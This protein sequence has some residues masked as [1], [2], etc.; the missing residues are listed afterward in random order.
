MKSSC[1]YLTIWYSLLI[2]FFLVVA[3]CTHRSTGVFPVDEG[4]ILT[5]ELALNFS[6]KALVECGK[7]S[8]MMKPVR[9][10]HSYPDGH[11]E[12]LFS[13]NKIDSNKGHV[14]WKVDDSARNWNYK[15][16]V[17]LQDG[18]LHTEIIRPH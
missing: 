12:F 18:E 3:G 15:V 10:S 4:T 7:G 6:R 8:D 17:C 16:K 13:R 1:K 2:P 11:Q 5:E 14:L 9:Y